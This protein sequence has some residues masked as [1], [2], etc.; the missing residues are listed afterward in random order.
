MKGRSAGAAMRQ[1][2]NERAKHTGG[3]TTPGSKEDATEHTPRVRPNAGRAGHAKQRHCLRA[4]AWVQDGTARLGTAPSRHAGRYTC[5]LHK[6]THVTR[7]L[8]RSW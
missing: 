1:W 3:T 7:R 2:R 5:A 8:L 6:R 4:K